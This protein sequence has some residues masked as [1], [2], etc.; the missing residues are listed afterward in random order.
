MNKDYV[1]KRKSSTVEAVCLNAQ[2]SM[3]QNAFDKTPPHN[4]C[5]ADVLRDIRGG[6][7]QKPIASIR[8]TYRRALNDSADAKKAIAEQKNKLSAFCVSGTAADRKTPLVHSGLLQIDLDGLGESLAAVREKMKCD[9]HVAFGFVSPSGDG[10]KLGLQID[11]DRHA[12]SFAAAQAYFRNT[13]EVEIDKRVKDKLRLCFVSHD[14][15]LWTNPD[16]TI[17][18]GEPVMQ[19]AD[20]SSATCTLQ[21]ATCNLHTTTCTLQPTTLHNTVSGDSVVANIKSARE[22]LDSLAAKKPLLAKLYKD[23]VEPRVQAQAHARNDFLVEAVPFLYRVAAPKVVLEFVECFYACNHALFSDSREQHM[24]E[25][26]AMLAGVANTYRGEL[27]DDELRVYCALDER[28]QDGFRI[29][30][31]LA[32]LPDP[33]REPM[34]FFLSCDQCATRL[35][36]PHSPQGQRVLCDLTRYGIIR[37]L[38][39]GTKRAAG[40]KGLATTYRWMLH[41]DSA[42]L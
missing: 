17:L 20:Y 1:L 9:P 4:H 19:N 7:Y 39:K 22:A 14:P 34:T 11:G 42:I 8:A 36:L 33:E 3:F 18:P 31:D 41:C 5:V 28:E 15:D 29:C 26:E 2:V 23:V 13:Y 40:V 37:Q 25:A 6:R 32:L 21:T 30:R 12:E 10:L 16:A 27:S 24:K 38:S 35:G